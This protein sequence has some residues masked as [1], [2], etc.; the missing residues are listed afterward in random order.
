MELLSTVDVEPIFDEFQPM[1]DETINNI[2]TTTPTTIEVTSALFLTTDLIRVD[3]STSNSGWRIGAGGGGV[4]RQR[5][6]T[7]V[8]S[9]ADE[10]LT[11]MMIFAH[12][13][14]GQLMVDSA[15][16]M[17]IGFGASPTNDEPNDILSHTHAAAST[18]AAGGGCTSLH[19][20]TL[21]PIIDPDRCRSVL[22]HSLR[23]PLLTS[24]ESGAM[25]AQFSDLVLQPGEFDDRPPHPFL[26]R[27]SVIS[28]VGAD[29]DDVDMFQPVTFDSTSADREF[30]SARSSPNNLSMSG[31]EG[32]TTPNN[33]IGSRD[34]SP[35]SRS[36]DD[37]MLTSSSSST[38]IP[39]PS[40]L[41]VDAGM[42]ESVAS[43]LDAGH[44]RRLSASKTPSRRRSVTKQS[45]SSI[46]M[47]EGIGPPPSPAAAN[48][49][50]G[51]L[52]PTDD[53]LTLKSSSGVS[54]SSGVGVLMRPSTTAPVSVRASIRRIGSSRTILPKSNGG[55]RPTRQTSETIAA[56]GMPIEPTHADTLNRT[57]TNDLNIEADT[58]PNFGPTMS[59]SHGVSATVPS[60][61]SGG[62][63]NQFRLE[64]GSGTSHFEYGGT[65]ILWRKASAR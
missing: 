33:Q 62:A 10:S 22:P 43:A 27:R 48:M 29:N 16:C 54:V 51:P 25:A 56:G 28:D 19:P 12:D 57:H 64:C 44:T 65:P 58:P 23:A 41:M 2:A 6:N 13:R 49:N 20:S 45:K 60:S 50:T 4:G 31:S 30:S 40:V 32:S 37:R 24:S 35:C 26:H 7:P 8:Q 36:N 55:G 14:G 59:V 63:T 34:S 61:S 5:N 11:N 47:S 3:S 39:S 42:S 53:L 52:Q 9:P 15:S 1:R 46:F 18:V 38:W 21:S 17:I